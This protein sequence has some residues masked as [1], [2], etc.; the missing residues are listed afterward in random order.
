IIDSLRK[1]GKKPGP[2]PKLEKDAII[3]ALSQTHGN[4]RNAAKQLNVSRATLYRYLDVYG[5]S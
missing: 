4:R 3:T 2:R 5:L 1:K